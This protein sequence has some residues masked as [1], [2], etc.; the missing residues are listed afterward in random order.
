MVCY[1]GVRTVFSDV[2]GEAV[3]YLEKE[4]HE[5]DEEHQPSSDLFVL[6]P[7]ITTAHVASERFQTSRDRGSSAGKWP[8]SVQRRVESAA[9]MSLLN[10]S[11]EG[12]IFA[13]V[14]M[15]PIPFKTADQLA[16]RRH[17]RERKCTDGRV[18]DEKQRH[19]YHSHSGEDGLS[20]SS[21]VRATGQGLG[22]TKRDARGYGKN[23]CCS[24]S[25]G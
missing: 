15:R 1:D 17:M 8:C 14:E 6:P 13:R 24:S 3:C 21:P 5:C 12:R 7:S 22:S 19:Q 25:D 20:L 18:V 23:T 2:G 10:A 4:R 9:L 16:W 11:N